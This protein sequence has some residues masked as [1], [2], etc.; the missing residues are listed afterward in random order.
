MGREI[1]RELRE[2]SILEVASEFIGGAPT[3]TEFSGTSYSNGVASRQGCVYRPAVPYLCG[4]ALRQCGALNLLRSTFFGALPVALD[5]R[6]RDS[7]PPP[8]LLKVPENLVGV[9]AP[10]MIRRPPLVELNWAF[11]VG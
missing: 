1:S 5:F 10:P 8:K 3:P 11:G 2:T 9:G 7:D 4:A 6:S